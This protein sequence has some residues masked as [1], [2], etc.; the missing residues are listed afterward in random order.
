LKELVYVLD[1]TDCIESLI[2]YQFMLLFIADMGSNH[3]FTIM[4]M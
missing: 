2:L 3:V 1:S 4:I